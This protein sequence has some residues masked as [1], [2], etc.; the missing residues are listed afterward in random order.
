M[1]HVLDSFNVVRIKLHALLQKDE[2]LY[3]SLKRNPAVM[4]FVPPTLSMPTMASTILKVD[5]EFES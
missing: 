3:A 5:D 1:K 2:H 4:L